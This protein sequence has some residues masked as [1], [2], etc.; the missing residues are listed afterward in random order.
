[1]ANKIFFKTTEGKY[2]SLSKAAMKPEDKVRKVMKEF[3]EG[4]LKSSSGQKVTER[5]Q[6]IA[7]AMSE[8]GMSKNMVHDVIIEFDDMEKARTTKYIKRIPKPTGKGYIYFYNKQQIKDYQD[9]GKLPDEKEPKKE[10]K[11]ILGA[12]SSLADFFG[13]TGNRGS[14]ETAFRSKINEEYSKHKD[15]LDGADI[16]SFA[17]HLNEFLSNKEKW[18]KKFSGEKKEKGE[19]KPKSEAPKSEKK[20]EIEGPRS[21]KKWNMSLMKSIAGI[22]GE[23]KGEE[24]KEKDIPSLEARDNPMETKIDLVS[25]RG[26][27][28]QALRDLEKMGVKS[29]KDYESL[30]ENIEL[31]NE[32]I[33]KREESK[34]PDNFET[35]PEGEEIKTKRELSDK[36]LDNLSKFD[37]ENTINVIADKYSDAIINSKTDIDKVISDAQKI[38]KL[39]IDSDERIKLQ[40]FLE[41]LSYEIEGIPNSKDGKERYEQIFGKPSPTSSAMSKEIERTERFP[42]VP[43]YAE[44]PEGF[45]IIKGTN[46]PIR[47]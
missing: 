21:G 47:S 10:R 37:R 34:S 27:Y 45:N 12:W 8:S 24:K 15:K 44:A 19:S 32:K 5:D 18:M 4:K 35:M 7:I 9:K 43:T 25:R 33:K 2:I 23:S 40:H 41:A 11:G 30:K 28:Q 13:I 38:N 20:S 1:M 39:D 31:I 46:A 3:K 17:Q 14:D 42:E 6:A 36:L 22:Y 16:S 29:G 26:R